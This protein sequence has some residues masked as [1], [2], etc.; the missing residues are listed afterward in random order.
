[1]QLGADL[2]FRVLAATSKDIF[3]KPSTGMF[4]FVV[5]LYEE[6]GWKIGE[7]DHYAQ[8]TADH[9]KTIFVGDAA[10]RKGDHSDTDFTMAL[11]AGIAF[12]TPEVRLDSWHC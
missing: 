8:L 12:A 2:P 5:K 4:D 10:G 11:N 3:R 7:Y 6:K 9:E 1:M